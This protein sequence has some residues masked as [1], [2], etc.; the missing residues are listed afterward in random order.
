MKKLVFKLRK[1][2]PEEPAGRI[3]T[4]TLAEHREK[5]LAGGR[6]FKYPVQ[7]QR[8]K[9]VIN[10]LIIG[11]AALL[12][13][14]AMVWYLLYVTKNTSDFMYR[15]TKVIPA[16]V[17]VVDGEPVQYSDY[18]MKYRSA[19]HYLIEKEQIDA[20]SADGKSQLS[21]VKSQAMDDAIADAYAS[22]LARELD[23]TVTDADLEAFLKQQ[24]QS[25]D[26]EVTE[27]TYN[28]VIRDYYGWSPQEYREAMKSKLLRQ[29][30]AYAVDAHAEDVSK[31]IEE[32]VKAGS[33]DLKAIATELNAA[34]ED[35]V[36][37]MAAAWVPKNNQDGGL[38]QAAAKLSKG[39]VSTAI[40]A[41]SG[42]GYY[43]VKLV[44]SNDSQVQYEYIHVPL[45][46]FDAKLTQ[47]EK[48]KKL[49][50]F[51]KIEDTATTQDDQQ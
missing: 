38:A 14:I 48:D 16:P 35:A 47:V 43:Y 5:V 3:T 8:H 49:T 9:L 30:V 6:K 34:E 36:T 32:K 2:Q 13:A 44:D 12:L 4:D 27:A 20:N 18:L 31:D 7:Y 51:I 25:S 22:K 46:E 15:V 17:A 21:Y 28:A 23:V 19:A 39:Q 10:A 11:I 1:K 33:A 37:Y 40:K 26:G 41:T 24:R 45:K 42:N 50:Q 29:K